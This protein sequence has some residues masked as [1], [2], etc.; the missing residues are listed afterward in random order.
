MNKLADN[1]FS[2]AEDL[3]SMAQALEILRQRIAIVTKDRL[4]QLPLARAAGRILSQNLVS[5]IDGPPP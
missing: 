5:A 2:Q 1:C 3:M 4:D